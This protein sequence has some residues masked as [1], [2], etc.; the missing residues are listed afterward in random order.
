M[1]TSLTNFKKYYRG[2]FCTRRAALI[3]IKKYILFNYFY[4]GCFYFILKYTYFKE[5]NRYYN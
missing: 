4:C 2:D 5:V 1:T 3:R